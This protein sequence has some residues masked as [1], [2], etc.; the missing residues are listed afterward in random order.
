MALAH[1]EPDLPQHAFLAEVHKAGNRAATLTRQ[2]LAFS[3]KS[4]LSPKVLD[5]NDL[6]RDAG[7]MLRRLIGEDIELITAYDPELP[8][9][10][11]DPSQ[12]EQVLMNL[13]VNA[14]DAMPQGGRLEVRTAGVQLG[15]ADTRDQ[16]EVRPGAYVLLT[17]RDTG[18]G[19]DEATRARIFEPF[20]TTKGIG[21]GTGLGLAM[22][23]GIVKQ[24]GG[25]IDV[26]TA[27]GQGTTFCIYLPSAGSALTEAPPVPIAADAPIGTET[28]LIAEDEEG[29]RD[30]VQQVL[31][32]SG[33]T[34]L[35][36]R[37]G[38]EALALVEQHPG[39]IHLL[40]TDVVMPRLGGGRLARRLLRL[41]P[42]TRV[43]FM[44]G[45][46]DSTLA[47][48][49]VVSGDADCL[50]KPFS[51]EALARKVRET[52]DAAAAG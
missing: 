2:L 46:A 5:V 30:L 12:L 32:R 11:A 49:E 37:D 28:V 44:S 19:M 9:V 35:E 25:H 14:R 17:V 39:P 50:I 48:H 41:R 47:R 38:E 3:R 7:K 51:A 1:V 52:L 36:A 15:E 43:L 10:K 8:P 34:V 21:K 24:S 18:I 31:R 6:I 13:V 4:L 20:F 23:Y 29:V 40:L 42:E 16:P 22:V 27:H 45:F 26:E 33:Y